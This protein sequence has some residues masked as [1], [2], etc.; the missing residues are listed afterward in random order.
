MENSRTFAAISRQSPGSF[1]KVQISSR[2]WITSNHSIQVPKEPN[3]FSVNILQ[4]Y[5]ILLTFKIAEWWAQHSTSSQSFCLILANRHRIWVISH[6]IAKKWK[7]LVSCVLKLINFLTKNPIILISKKTN[8][9]G[10]FAV[11]N[12]SR[13][14]DGCKR[15]QRKSFDPWSNWQF[16]RT[17]E[18]S[19]SCSCSCSVELD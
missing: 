11:E 5:S 15:F 13:L 8:I 2:F 18:A 17:V 10:I 1:R 4:N 6:K 7:I 12:G 19:W 14:H 3:P 16:K 9:L